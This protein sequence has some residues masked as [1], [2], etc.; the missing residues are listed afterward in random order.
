MLLP[1]NENI[2]FIVKQE[3][4]KILDKNNYIFSSAKAI[5]EQEDFKA[6]VAMGYDAVPFIVNAIDERP[7][8]LPKLK[9]DQ[10][11]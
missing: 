10:D 6:I 5:I 11:F 2:Y 9:S 7:S 4:N 3:Y 1:V 8:Y